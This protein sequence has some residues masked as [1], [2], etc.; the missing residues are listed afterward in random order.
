MN[1]NGEAIDEVIDKI[2]DVIHSYQGELS[3]GF[4]FYED[5][6]TW[7]NIRKDLKEILTPKKTIKDIGGVREVT[8]A[9]A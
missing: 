3:D 9:N 1:E 5:M 7:D 6:D 8:N 2:I 4:A